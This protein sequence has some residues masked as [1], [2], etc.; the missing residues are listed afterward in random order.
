MRLETVELTVLVALDCELELEGVQPT[1][2][3]ESIVFTCVLELEELPNPQLNQLLG[4]G[5]LSSLGFPQAKLFDIVVLL[6]LS[7]LPV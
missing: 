3:L 2:V 4:F 5:E 1:E 7:S 6:L